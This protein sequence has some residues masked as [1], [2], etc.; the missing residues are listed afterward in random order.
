MPAPTLTPPQLNSQAWLTSVIWVY[1]MD[2]SEPEQEGM[3]WYRPDGEG[4]GSW[5]PGAEDKPHEMNAEWDSDFLFL[6]SSSK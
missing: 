2:K 1:E 3:C 4:P 5:I 6:A